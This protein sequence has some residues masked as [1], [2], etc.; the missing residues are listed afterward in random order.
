MVTPRV[1]HVVCIRGVDDISLEEGVQLWR[2]LV[3]GDGMGDDVAFYLF[4]GFLGCFVVVVVDIGGGK[5][6]ECESESETSP[7]EE[8]QAVMKDL[9]ALREVRVDFL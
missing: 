5:V 7:R 8:S 2:W 4:L 9:F 6:G 1:R 3:L